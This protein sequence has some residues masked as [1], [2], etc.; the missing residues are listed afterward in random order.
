MKAYRGREGNTPHMIDHGI[1]IDIEWSALESD[2]LL[3]YTFIRLFNYFTEL[4]SPM[5]N[6]LSTSDVSHNLMT[7]GCELYI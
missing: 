2:R 4:S 3:K 1:H 5:S 7:S 6:Y